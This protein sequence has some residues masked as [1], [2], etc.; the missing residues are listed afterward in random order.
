MHGT[1]EIVREEGIGGIYRGLFPVAMR[2]GANSAVRFTSYSTL[3]VGL[4][5][6]NACSETESRLQ[7]LCIWQYA[8][9]RDAANRRNVCS[10]CRCRPDHRLRNHAS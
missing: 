5:S 10:R 6:Q 2:Q 9:R 3:K 7:V 4:L 8:A 1:V